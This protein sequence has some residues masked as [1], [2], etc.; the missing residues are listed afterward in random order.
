L[1]RYRSRLLAKG[2]LD[3]VLAGIEEAAAAEVDAATVAAKAGPLPSQELVEKDVWA[4]GG[5]SW[6]N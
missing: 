6:R 4:D 3:D 2:I 5:A 1:A